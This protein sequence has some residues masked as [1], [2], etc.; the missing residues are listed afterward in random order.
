M[1]QPDINPTIETVGTGYIHQATGYATATIQKWA[2]TGTL[3]TPI[4][5]KP[6][7]WAKHIIDRWLQA[8]YDNAEAGMGTKVCNVCKLEK[9][10][11]EFHRLA[12]SPDGHQYT[13]K[14]CVKKRRAKYRDA[15]NAHNRGV[16][17]EERRELAWYRENY[18]QE[19]KPWNEQ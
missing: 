10:L 17:A 11:S 12:T 5:V 15:Q 1:A 18:P 6:Y 7:R 8:N 3:P 9:P 4:S 13:C 16:R 14:D 2:R 19:G